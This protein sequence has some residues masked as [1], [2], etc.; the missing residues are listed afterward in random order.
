MVS[1]MCTQ[2]RILQIWILRAE[3][4][5]SATDSSKLDFKGGFGVLYVHSATDSEKL[6]FKGGFGVLYLHS[7]TDS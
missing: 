1:Y 7:A 6:D 2:L 4:P 5:H 3:T